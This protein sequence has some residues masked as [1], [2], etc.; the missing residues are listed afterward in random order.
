MN[1]EVKT[2]NKFQTILGNI[3]SNNICTD[4]LKDEYIKLT[5]EYKKLSK[6]YDRT[7]KM[8][9][10]EQHGSLHEKESLSE[11]KKNIQIF[12]RNKIM[13]GVK[14]QRE[15]KA[16]VEEEKT[17]DK[18]KIDQLKNTVKEVT[19]KYHKALHQIDKL[20]NKKL[21][22]S[23]N[24]TATKEEYDSI[25]VTKYRKLSYPHIINK[26]IEDT[27]L[28][29]KD[30]VIIKFTADN[31][32]TMYKG[33]SRVAIGLLSSIFKS[34]NG[35]LMGQDIMYYS[36]PDI[37]YIL[38]QDKNID[39]SKSIYQMILAPREINKLKMYFS[40][41]VTEFKIDD[42]YDTI[43]H[44]LDKAYEEAKLIKNKNSIS[45]K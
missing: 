13:E 10:K 16:I 1:R 33:D 14:Q 4:E 40:L 29:S 19:I 45:I 23:E 20:S 31:L 15:I 24:I 36:Y 34:I 21:K 8:S 3:E 43:N 18:Q 22:Y 26:I 11:D 44:R 42:T 12:A 39:E 2:I 7:I 17:T 27:K 25:N 37:F 9:D 6:R 30:L 38:L 5:K 32:T 35:S 28:Y 41:G